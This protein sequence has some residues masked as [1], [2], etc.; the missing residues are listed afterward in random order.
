MLLEFRVSNFRSFRDEVVLSLA[1]APDDLHLETHTRPTGLDKIKRSLN[2]VAIFGPNAGGKTNIVLALQF[3]QSMVMTSNQVAPDQD[4]ILMPFRLRSNYTDHA[5]RFEA[6]FVLFGTRFQY[7][8]ELNRKR[9]MEEWLLVYEKAKPQVWFSRTY[10]A[11]RNKYDFRFSDYFLGTKK[12][13]EAATRKETLF[14]TTAVQLNNEQLKPIYQQFA[15]EMAIFPQGGSIGFGYSSGY[16]AE[17][18]N[19]DKVTSLISAADT[20]ISRIGM[21]KRPGRQFSIDINSGVQLHADTDVHIP[22]FGHHSGNKVYD[23]E[24]GEESSGTQILF[25]LSGP[26]LDILERGRI[27][28]V[29]ELDR[30][31]HPILVDMLVGLFNDP[32]TN[33]NG[34]QLIFTTHDVS[35]MA[36]QKLRRDQIWFAEKDNEQVSHLFSLLE[37]SP[38]KQEALEKGYLGGRY[39]G[40]PIIGNLKA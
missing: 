38:R 21:D 22:L 32:S 16:V 37:F 35:L 40:I 31:L 28:V 5:S 1:A 8:F 30:S 25:N 19:K 2:S 7:G 39:G 20:G 6:T 36:N 4:N 18:R 14:L 27:L 29:D 12:V 9:I 26:I 33:K 10:D 17:D 13:L 3:M 15:E 11:K 24:Y 23:I 34:A